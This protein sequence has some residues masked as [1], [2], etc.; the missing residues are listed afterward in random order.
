MTLYNLVHILITL[1]FS[2]LFSLPGLVIPGSK[3]WKRRLI[4]KE[5][6]FLLVENVDGC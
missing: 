3:G 6:D 5:S 2:A 1:C 4:S